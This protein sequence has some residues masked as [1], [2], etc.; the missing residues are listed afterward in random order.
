MNT[1]MKPVLLMAVFALILSGC[2]GWTGHGMGLSSHESGHGHH[3]DS[4]M[5]P[6]QPCTDQDKPTERRQQSEC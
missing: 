3:Y 5:P 1:K 6:P 2:V 4:K